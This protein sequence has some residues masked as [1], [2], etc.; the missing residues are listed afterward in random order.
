[1]GG[2]PAV[3]PLEAG[4]GLAGSPQALALL[5]GLS[6]FFGLAFEEFYARRRIDLPGGV[7][8]FPLLAL[9]GAAL[10]TLE[11]VHALA[12]SAGLLVL[13]SWLYLYYRMRVAEA[14]R[15][16]AVRDADAPR[17]LGLMA[18]V[19]NLLAYLLGPITLRE[20]VWVPIGLT[21]SAVLLLGA[22]EQLHRLAQRIPLVEITTL[23]K[24]LI[25]TGIVLPLLPDRP[26]TALSQLTPYRVWLAVVAI[27]SL[28]YASYLLQRYVSPRDG[29]TWSAVLG[30][31]YSSTATTV[32]LSR[33]IRGEGGAPR[34]IQSGIILA[35]GL[36]YLRIGLV[37]AVFNRALA[38]RLAPALALLCLAALGL[39]LLIHRSASGTTAGRD[40]EAPTNPLEISAALVFA[41]LFVL[42]SV[43]ATW[44]KGAFG[45]A[46]LFALAAVV[47]VTDIDPFVL[48]LAQGAVHGLTSPEMVGA[49]LVAAS[50]NNLLK[51]LYSGIFGSWRAAL[52][53]A[54]ALVALAAAGFAT[55]WLGLPHP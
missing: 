6:F 16:G 31:L 27:S 21:V 30:G 40:V 3:S 5:L 1:M 11:P 10:Y 44:V 48:A 9:C 38:E 24:F 34:E 33:R 35:T 25:L 4:G 15:T 20:P 8:T 14:E 23:G 46:G 39:A 22:R 12:F 50:S 17:G 19:C 49:I 26:V 18:P 37:V 43:A 53:P 45:A 28:S 13:G 42:V 51:A 7:R 29:V 54:A 52:A 47:G 41:A 2:A 55:A 32:V 36:M